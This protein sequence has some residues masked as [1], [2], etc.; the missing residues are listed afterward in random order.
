M[1]RFSRYVNEHW[2][3]SKVVNGFCVTKKEENKKQQLGEILIRFCRERRNPS[4]F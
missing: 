3:I 2:S 4:C 1:P